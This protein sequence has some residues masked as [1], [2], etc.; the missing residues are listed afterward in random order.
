MSR[1]DGHTIIMPGLGHNSEARWF[2]GTTCER[3]IKLPKDPTWCQSAGVQDAPEGNLTYW[4][5]KY[6][7]VIQDYVDGN[8][9]YKQMHDAMTSNGKIRKF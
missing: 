4:A 6:C 3:A 7:Q 1:F 9:T 8:S 2:D 5:D